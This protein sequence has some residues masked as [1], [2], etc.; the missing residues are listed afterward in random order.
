MDSNDRETLRE[1]AYHII[2]GTESRAGKTFD[3]VLL[4]LIVL[5]VLVVMLDSVEA[6]ST[7]HHEIFVVVEWVLT[8]L[9]TFEYVAR[10]MCVRKPFAYARSFYGLVDLVSILPTYLSLFLAGTHPFLIIRI[11]RVLRVFRV[12]KLMNYLVEGEMIV[13]ALRAS[14]RKISV[15]L[16]AILGVVAIMGSFMYVIEGPEHGFSS[17]PRSIYWAVVTLTTVGYGDIS[18]HTPLGQAVAAFVMILGYGMI[19]VPTGIV[20]AEMTLHHHKKVARI[21]PVCE[22]RHHAHD[23]KFCKSCGEALIE[24]VRPTRFEGPTRR[25]SGPN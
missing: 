8:I 12:L 25:S 6:I 7:P 11:L 21:C 22:E 18:P 10:L 9:F 2:F 13:D 16:F 19:A 15:F 4:C 20:T 3:V 17:I 5:S 1:R 14:H 24:H 23:A